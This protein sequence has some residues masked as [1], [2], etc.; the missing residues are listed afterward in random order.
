MSWQDD[1]QENV[2]MFLILCMY[3]QCYAYRC[4]KLASVDFMARVMRRS[5]FP[6]LIETIFEY[7]QFSHSWFVNI[8]F[9]LTLF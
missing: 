9:G 1:V 4:V 6:M 8:K 2:F 7:I 5:V 3:Y